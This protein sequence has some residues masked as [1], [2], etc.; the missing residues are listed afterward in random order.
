MLI[1]FSRQ[2]EDQ[3]SG[4]APIASYLAELWHFALTDT[5]RPSFGGGE[6]GCTMCAH[7]MTLLRKRETKRSLTSGWLL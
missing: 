3:E 2:K 5:W 4:L 6:C 1:Y 7:I